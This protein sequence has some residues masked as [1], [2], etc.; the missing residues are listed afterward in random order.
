MLDINSVTVAHPVSGTE[1][2]RFEVER[3]H[4]ASAADAALAT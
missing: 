4:R 3:R 1:R 2:I